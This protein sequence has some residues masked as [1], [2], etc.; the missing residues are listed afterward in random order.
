[1][2]EEQ[3][4]TEAE[5]SGEEAPPA[6]PPP[7]TPPSA[8]PTVE[9]AVIPTPGEPTPATPPPAA[10]PP[11]EPAKPSADKQVP[12]AA[13]HEAREINRALKLQIEDLGRQIAAI[14]TP[15][16][17]PKALITEDPEQAVAVLLAKIDDLR[18]EID[19]RDMERQI[20]TDVPDF[21]EKAPQ[22]EEYLFGL[23]FDEEGVKNL[24]GSSGSNAPKLFKMI[25][26]NISKPDENAI[27][28]KVTAELTP[29]ITEQ[30]TKQLMEKF[31]IVEPPTNLSKL[32]GAGP[33]GKL[34]VE[35]E[36]DYAKL[37]PEQQEKWLSGEL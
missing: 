11:A 32:P 16:L 3:V 34:A 31:K 14:K 18:A 30:V 22:M 4:Y 5:L 36:S 10:T 1:M 27:R 15:T 2:S 33:T 29:V 25:S 6:T 7:A 28:A 24:I 26:D 21:F 17:D 8:E 13:L 35:T 19:R 9:K 12:L 23:G 20:K 37:P